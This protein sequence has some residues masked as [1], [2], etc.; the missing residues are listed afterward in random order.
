MD[1]QTLR[2]DEVSENIKSANPELFKILDA[3]KAIK[4]EIFSIYRYKYGDIVADEKNFYLPNN[5]VE[6]HTKIPFGMFLTKRFGLFMSFNDTI[7]TDETY[8]PGELINISKIIEKQDDHNTIDMIS[9]C[10]GTRNPTFVGNMIYE[11]KHNKIKRFLKNDVPKP[12]KIM[13]HFNTIRDIAKYADSDWRAELLAFPEKWVN[14]IKS[15]KSHPFKEYIYQYALKKS[16]YSRYI[17][18]Y[19][20]ILSHIKNTHSSSLTHNSYMNNI[21][22]HIFNITCG[23]T[24]AFSLANNDESMPLSLIEDIYLNYYQPDFA[25]LVFIPSSFKNKNKGAH[26]FS[27]PKH[28]AV[29]KPT[30]ISST[31]K[32]C[33]DVKELFKVYG[34]GIKELGFC[35]ETKFYN[36]SQQL[37]LTVIHERKGLQHDIGNAIL[38]SDIANYDVDI[39]NKIDSFNERGYKLQTP[40]RSE[41]FNGS[42]GL[43]LKNK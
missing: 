40:K 10:A 12:N 3:D 32:V 20:L 33:S 15:K 17:E 43:K 19:Y 14:S 1:I 42:L 28:T 7:V 27:I 23:T 21:V 18:Y 5:T 2:W 16:A 25:P 30:S 6:H 31:L 22:R 39:K 37:E 36:I 24:P 35:H 38:L 4:S 9:I 34:Q 11:Q 26:Y 41:F 8:V 13:N 29:Y